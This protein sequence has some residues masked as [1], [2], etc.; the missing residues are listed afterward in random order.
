MIFKR[1]KRIY[2]PRCKAM[3]E[4]DSGPEQCD[5]TSGHSGPHVRILSWS[6]KKWSCKVVW[7]KPL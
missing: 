4:C 3:I 5:K 7:R 1:E 6:G 2:K